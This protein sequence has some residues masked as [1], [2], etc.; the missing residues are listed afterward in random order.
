MSKLLANKVAIIT[1]AGQGIGFAIAKKMAE[2]GARIVVNDY[3]VGPSGSGQIPGL[4]E[5]AVMEIRSDGGEAVPNVNSVETWQGG[6]EIIET[7]IDNY[8]RVDILVNNAGIVLDKMIF[9]LTEE[10]WNKIL[11]VNLYG[12]FYC[13]R[14]A[15]EVMKKNKYGRIINMSSGAGLGKTLGCVN[16]AAAKEGIIGLTRA[17]ARDMAKYNVTCNAIRP[18]AQTRHF[19]EKRK[20]AWIRQGKLTELKEMENSRPED[21]AAFATYL[22]ADSAGSVTGRTFFVGAGKIS[23]YSEPERISTIFRGDGQWSMEKISKMLSGIRTSSDPDK[24]I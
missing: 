15:A 10:D 7:A 8:G 21:V 24:Q 9:N 18:L 14:A 22:A 16:Y 4:A 2:E 20:Q 1:G 12:T 19:D 17:V 6:K 23:L 13:I 3:G 5:K 11:K